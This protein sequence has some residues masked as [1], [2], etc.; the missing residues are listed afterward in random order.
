MSRR[1][2]DI[3]WL[4][5]ALPSLKPKYPP[6]PVTS[7]FPGE[8]P[9]ASA[10]SSPSLKAAHSG[11]LQLAAMAPF[12]R[13]RMAPGGL[14]AAAGAERLTLGWWVR[15][16]RLCIWCPLAWRRQRETPWQGSCFTWHR[17]PPFSLILGPHSS[18]D[19]PGWIERALVS[20]KFCFWKG[21]F[22]KTELD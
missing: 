3:P 12:T 16:G 20:F 1:I 10:A 14:E 8:T 17:E 9:H 6:P 5:S 18:I 13:C 4:A 7:T 22:I 21:Y 2:T 11:L 19:H 15:W